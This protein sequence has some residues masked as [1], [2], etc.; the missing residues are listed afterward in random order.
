MTKFAYNNFK[1]SF[2][3]KFSFQIV[4]DRNFYMN[5]ELFAKH[6]DIVVF[7]EKH[8]KLLKIKK[9]YVHKQLKKS[10]AYQLKYYNKKHTSKLFMKKSGI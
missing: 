9:K 1:H 7:A 4:Y 10:Q 5:F 3:E 2:I 8:E 6:T